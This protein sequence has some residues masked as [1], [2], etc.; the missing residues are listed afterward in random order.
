M[1]DPKGADNLATSNP[2]SLSPDTPSTHI[3]TALESDAMAIAQLHQRAFGPGRFALTAYR[4]REAGEFD[5]R[6]NQV[7]L[8]DNEIVGAVGFTPIEI[9]ETA[10]ALLL[11][12]LAVD[13]K[14]TNIG[15][16]SHLI[17]AGSHA[18]NSQ[19]IKL[20]IL[21]G[22][23][24]FYQRLGFV[25][26]PPGQITMPGPVNPARLLALELSPGALKDYR[27]PITA[28]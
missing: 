14:H 4:V 15:L 2:T 7:A 26:V 25:A 10:N 18:A 20:I 23:L 13:P 1:G 16:G 19:G 21:V 9:G 12:P 3:R 17:R 11:G 24:A 6:C 8:V 22:D 28:A 27:G 5:M